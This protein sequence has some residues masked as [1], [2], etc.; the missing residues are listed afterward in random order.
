MKFHT[1]PDGFSAIRNRVVIIM[2]VISSFIIALF[3][4]EGGDTVFIMIPF[5]IILIGG[6][7]WYTLK[8][9][10]EEYLSFTLTIGEDFVMRESVTL[11]P[12]TMRT[13]EIVKIERR[14][15]GSLIIAGTGRAY[16]I[17]V[18]P[19]MD[20]YD[21]MITMLSKLKPVI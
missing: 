8:K 19:G 2:A 14:K 9:Q 18:P 5:F 21:T 13:A 12:V 4:K 1:K 11:P 3:I 15:N 6:T 10:K 16:Q 20:N 17:A 7:V